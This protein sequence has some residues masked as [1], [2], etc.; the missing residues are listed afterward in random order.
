MSLHHLFTD[1]PGSV[2]ESYTQH[3]AVAGVFGLRMILGGLACLV[4][5][6]LPFLF[7]RTGSNFVTDLHQR[8]V[9]RQRKPQASAPIATRH[10]G[11]AA[12]R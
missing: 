7:Q 5:A 12:T 1:H 4:H 10:F 9:A 3:L 2:G 8:M 11:R 6:V